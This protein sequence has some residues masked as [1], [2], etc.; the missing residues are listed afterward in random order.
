MTVRL[1]LFGSPTIEYVGES[2]TLPSERRSHLLAFL[3]LKRSWVGRAEVAALLWPEQATKLAYTNLRKTLFRLQS[4]PYASLMDVQGGALRFEVDTDV[5]AF[6]SSLRERNLADALA[7]RRG[8]LLAGFEDDSNEAWSSWLNFERD[9]LR[10][11]WR[12]AAIDRLAGDIDPAEGVELSALLLEADPLDEAALRAHMTWLARDGRS[13]RAREAYRD[14]AGRLAEDL[15]LAPGS[16]LKTL[17]DSLASPAALTVPLVATAPPT[18]AD[19]FVG[20]AVELRRIATLFAGGECRLVSL[21]GPGGVGKS[22]LARRALQEL[23]SAYSDGAAF[24]P[25]EDIASIDELGARIARELDI[26]LTGGQEPLAQV[27]AYLRTRHVL[28]VLDNFEHLAPDASILERLLGACERLAMVVTSRVRLALAMEWML[29]LEGLPFPEVEDLD[30]VDSFDAVRLF[31]QSSQRVAPGLVPAAEA[32][33]IV[34]ICRQVEGLPLALELAATWTRVLSCE[35][36]AAELRSGIGLL[37]AVDTAR[38]ARHASIEVVFEQSW[39]LLSPVERE[40][41]AR[42][43]VLRGGFSPEAARAIAGASL[44]VLAALTDKSLL[45]KEGARIFMHPLV[46]Q[47]AAVRLGDGEARETAERAHAGYFHRMLVQLRRAVG[48][49]DRDALLWVDAEFENCKLAWRWAHTHGAADVLAK[50]VRTLLD[51]C[52]YRGRLNEGLSLLREAFESR[53]SQ[54]DSTLPA[55]LLAAMAH[56]EYRLDRYADAE[57]TATRALAAN[58][59]HDAKLQCFTVLG[60]CSLRMGRPADAKR[61]YERA[62]KQ[63]PAG[64]DPHNAAATLDNLALVEKAMGRYDEAL[65]LSLQSLAQHQRLRDVAGEALCLNNLGVLYLFKEEPE[66]AGA[67]LREGLSICDRHGLVS[68]RG[69]ILAN[70]AEVALLQGDLD[71]VGSYAGRAL[72]VAEVAGNRALV[73]VLKLH[74]VRLALRRGDLDSAR[75]NLEASLAIASAIERPSLRLTGVFCFAEVLAAQGEPECAYL[76]LAYVAGHPAMNAAERDEARARLAQW[77]RPA[78]AAPAWPGMELDELV[79]RIIVETGI[80]HAPLIA[81]LRAAL[82]R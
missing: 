8:E 16:D 66:S 50:S 1:F 56:L 57:A 52:D 54:A 4:W 22:R 7:A 51:F 5:L 53:T 26:R 60:G 79:H 74:F 49:G 45:R 43:S 70:L 12:N 73:C 13:A 77:S 75:A 40:A 55:R 25:L 64:I 9:R 42:L 2:F 30:R 21:V 46:Q 71:A 81:T 10:T 58:P 11:A 32:A 72:E 28:L 80:A 23:G 33:S 24:V 44:P 35:A 62:L 27:I 67:H 41:L 19:G 48:D 76:V 34:D 78:G 18:D 37:H 39:R 6:E 38:P 68:T 20:R 47:L 36:I 65:R 69:L 31:V 15:G 29:P 82:A 14:F 63:A 3:A 59:D 17:H 61:Y